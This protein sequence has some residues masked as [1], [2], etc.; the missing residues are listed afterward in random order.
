MSF[1]DKLPFEWTVGLRYTRAGKRSSRN[2]FISF[3]SL[4]SVACIALG[5]S[6]LIIVLSV[7][8]GFQKEVTDRMLSVLAHI[9]IFDARGGMPN[10]QQSAKAAFQ[11]PAVKGAAPFAETQGM[12]MADGVMRPAVVRGVLPSEE[13]KV[14]DV[15]RHMKEGRFDTL[16]EGQFN[17]LLGVDLAKSLELKIGDKVT[18]AVAPGQTTAQGM[19]P[20]MVNFTLTGIFESGHFEFDNALAIV[21]M[22]DAMSVANLD[23]PAGIRLRLADMHQAPFVAQ[24]L[25]R[26]MPGELLI[27]DWSRQNATWFAAVQ[28]Q[29]KMLF[30]ILAMI[31][32]VASFNLV[33][34]LVMTVTDKQ[35]DIAILRTLGASPPSIMKIFMIQGT[36]IGILGTLLGVG[37]G[38]LVALNITTWM[39]AI[40]GLFGVHLI[41]K[42]IYLINALPS[43][44]RWPDVMAIGAVTMVLAFLATLYPSFAASRVKPAEALRYE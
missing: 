33:S 11:N 12:L 3:I 36:L 41:S 23:A 28:S 4:I 40:E 31:I 7:V 24:E 16:G 30:T 38:V 9:E 2:S 13:G 17:I 43:D 37:F 21:H 8:N 5:V 19:V 32:A 25:V 39:P 29:K 27:R 35:S 44:L 20:R 34:M 22:V 1:I 42:E 14:S 26:S 10:W 15:P 18:M 6:A